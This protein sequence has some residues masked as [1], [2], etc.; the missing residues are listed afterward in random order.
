MPVFLARKL[1]KSKLPQL[2]PT[3]SL[4]LTDMSELDVYFIDDEEIIRVAAEQALSLAGFRVT[5]FA[6]A[7]QVISKLG[8]NLYEWPGIMVSDI[9]MPGKSGLELLDWALEQDIQLPLILISG[10]ADIPTAVKSIQDG[11]YDFVEK[12]FSSA[13]L[14][15]VV[16]RAIDKRTLVLDNRLLRKK[17]SNQRK[18]RKLLGCSVAIQNLNKTIEHIAQTTADV[19]VMGETGTGKELV[20]KCLHEY[21]PRKNEKFVAVNCGAMPES[22]FESELFGHVRGA[23]TNAFNNQVGKL[24]YANGGTFF[25][26][27]IES[28]PIN[29]QI[30]LLRVLQER[31]TQKIGCNQETN[32]DIRVV[33]AT[34]E[35]LLDASKQGSFREDL[36]YR[37]N[38]IAITIPPLRDRKEDIPILLQ[39]FYDQACTRAH[40]DVHPVPV[41][42]LKSS[43]EHD[44]PG[45]VRE[46][47]NYAERAAIAANA[48]LEPPDGSNSGIDTHLLDQLHL[49][50]VSG[51][52]SVQRTVRDSKDLEKSATFSAVA[53]QPTLQLRMDSVEKH[54]IEQELQRLGGSITKTYEALGISRKTLYDKMKKHAI[55]KESATGKNTRP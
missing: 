41:A 11:A 8:N 3:N 1:W 37:L 2:I 17:L 52:T 27:E 39:H 16:G 6:S 20:A 50:P 46:L 18:D 15:E 45:N 42:W 55:S 35:N 53:E 54:L 13:S 30:K 5:C 44:W 10:H 43:M 23:F 48:G 26:D 9:K 28:M 49:A 29:L 34:K 22:L 51:T 19:L 33:A 21:G 40:L 14:C 4:R 24:E 7:D 47:R 32:L 31:K 38:V 25:L 36:Y 12:P